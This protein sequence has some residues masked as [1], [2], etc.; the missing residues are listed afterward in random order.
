MGFDRAKVFM[1][2]LATQV[3]FR[4]TVEEKL[5]KVPYST[6]CD[7]YLDA[8]Q[9]IFFMFVVGNALATSLAQGN[10]ELGVQVELIFASVLSASWI[11]WNLYFFISAWGLV[12]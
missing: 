3:T 12:K 8:C 7:R 2:I 1:T 9:G 5:P 11:I 4:L 10:H 6:A